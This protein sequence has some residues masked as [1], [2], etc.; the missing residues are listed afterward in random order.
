VQIIGGAFGNAA[1]RPEGPTRS[2]ADSS[3]RVSRLGTVLTLSPS[4]SGE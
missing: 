1:T 4:Q 3:P 2:R